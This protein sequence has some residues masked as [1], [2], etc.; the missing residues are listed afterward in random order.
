MPRWRNRMQIRVQQLFH[1][2]DNIR[3]LMIFKKKS[4]LLGYST[5]QKK[6]TGIRKCVEMTKF[7]KNS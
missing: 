3:R 4:K 1:Q 7:G 6:K 2:S 5:G